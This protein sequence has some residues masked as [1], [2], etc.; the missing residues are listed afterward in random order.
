MRPP[1]PSRSRLPQP[2]AADIDAPRL[3]SFDDLVALVGQKRELKLKH[4][5]ET[6]VRLVR[7][8]VGRIEIAPTEHAEPGLAGE[9]SKKL[10]QWTGAR[11]MITVSS[12]GSAP[13]IAETR[14]SARDRMVDD[15]RADPLVGAVLGRFPGAEIVDVRVP[16]GE[17]APAA[18]AD[19]AAPAPDEFMNED[20]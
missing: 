14:Q 1:S 8:E 11:W 2:R 10:E 6:A 15:A 4:A 16:A 20:E 7:F 17:G 3:G 18:E 12:E 13:T 19:A 9:L 5:L